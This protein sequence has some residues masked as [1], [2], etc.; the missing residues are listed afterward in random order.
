[1]QRRNFIQNTLLATG[2]LSFGLA[3]ATTL[4]KKSLLKIA[5]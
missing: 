3:Q 5:F 4:K 1:M 2:A